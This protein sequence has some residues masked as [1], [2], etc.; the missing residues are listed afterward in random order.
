MKAIAGVS[1]GFAVHDI[2]FVAVVKTKSVDRVV[3]VDPVDDQA[4]V[5]ALCF[6]APTTSVAL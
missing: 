1:F 5:F 3:G 2:Q 4:L 6:Q